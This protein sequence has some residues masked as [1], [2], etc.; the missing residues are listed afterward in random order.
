M[1]DLFYFEKTIKLLIAS[2]YNS[3]TINPV[4][5]ILSAMRTDINLLKES[6]KEFSFIRNYIGMS[7]EN[8]LKKIKNIFKVRNF[9][10]EKDVNNSFENYENKNLLFHGSKVF[11][12]VGILSNGLKIAPK[13]AQRCGNIYGD[14][15]YFADN[16]QKSLNYCDYFEYLDSHKKTMRNK[17][18]LL[19]EVALGKVYDYN[20]NPSKIKFDNNF[21]KISG[22]LI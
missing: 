6:D 3:K 1:D 21:K 4:D 16:F 11:N 12:F 2:I 17:Y 20:E 13:E 22:N 7:N 5:Y 18:M 10:E 19:C 8:N 9:S 14:G 15:I